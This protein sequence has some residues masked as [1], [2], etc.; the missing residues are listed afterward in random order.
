MIFTVLL[1]LFNAVTPFKFITEV[2][3]NEKSIITDQRGSCAFDP[4]QRGSADDR[5]RG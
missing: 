3:K 4:Y 2:F 5:V 1:R